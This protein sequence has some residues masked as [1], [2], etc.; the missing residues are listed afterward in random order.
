MASASRCRA[1]VYMVLSGGR[2][3]FL[4][5]TAWAAGLVYQNLNLKYAVT[6]GH[7][8][9]LR[10]PALSRPVAPSSRKGHRGCKRPLIRPEQ[11]GLSPGFTGHHPP[12]SNRVLAS[13]TTP[14]AT[15]G[16]G[17]AG[18]LLHAPRS[19]PGLVFSGLAAPG[20]SWLSFRVPG[21]AAPP[22]SLAV[23]RGQSWPQITVK[24]QLWAHGAGVS[25]RPAGLPEASCFHF[26]PRPTRTSSDPGA[27][28]TGPAGSP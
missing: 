27:S 1:R 18:L 14:E 24:E 15:G 19:A 28:T 4:L 21:G 13:R 2:W 6:R 3:L 25:R 17:G 12:P 5:I 9:L 20:L 10:V 23:K 11:R 7:S 16:P 8:D 26:S 22:V